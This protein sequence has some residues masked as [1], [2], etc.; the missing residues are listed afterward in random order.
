MKKHYAGASFLTVYSGSFDWIYNEGI[1][2]DI[3]ALAQKAALKMYAFEGD[4][5]IGKIK[6]RLFSDGKTKFVEEEKINT[7]LDCLI[8]SNKKEVV[9]C[10]IIKKNNACL[11][12]YRKD[13][14]VYTLKEGDFATYLLEAIDILATN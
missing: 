3:Y 6:D 9:R 14:M 12:L 8:S 4:S 7:V 5:D 10:S 11:F 13:E 2:E 1:F